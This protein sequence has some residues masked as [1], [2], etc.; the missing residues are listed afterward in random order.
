LPPDFFGVGLGDLA[1]LYGI[2]Y[3]EVHELVEAPDFAFDAN[4]QLLIQPDTNSGMCLKKLEDLINWREQN[5]AIA[6][7]TAAGHFRQGS[8]C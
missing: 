6:S 8:N 5:P 4:R 3:H 7:S 2:V 1:D